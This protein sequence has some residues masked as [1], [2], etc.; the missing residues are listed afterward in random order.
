[1][2]FLRGFLYIL[3]AFFTG[4]FLM[5]LGRKITARIQR[6]FGP[7]LWQ[8]LYDLAKLFSKRTNISH[9]IMMDFSV[10]ILLAG[11]LLALFFLPNPYCQNEIYAGDIIVLL[12]VMLFP[13]LGMAL[14]VGEAANPNGSIGISRA[15]IMLLG[16]DFILIAV[17]VG[18]AL[19]L[20]GNTYF[21]DIVNSQAAGVL[22]WNIFRFPLFAFAGFFATLGMMHQEPFEVMVAPHEIAT[23]PM[24]EF[25]GRYLG[26]LFLQHSF[27]LFI[28]TGIFV[29]LFLGGGGILVFTLKIIIVFVLSL[30]VN[31]VFA[32]FR[33]EQAVKFFW[34]YPFL[35]A[36][37]GIILIMAKR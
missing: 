4:I 15:L 11:T 30:L 26:M 23:G 20:D 6:R 34:K 21:V 14:G 37:L 36:L 3:A 28:E 1:L 8:P 10:I 17:V 29:N 9:G 22:S 2:V 12:Y 18:I 19:S 7:P 31:S 35:A 13:S 33:T 5:G 25:G 24:V 32:R 27:A 16:Y